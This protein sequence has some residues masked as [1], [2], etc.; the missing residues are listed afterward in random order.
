MINT[1]LLTTFFP[2]VVRRHSVFAF[3]FV[4]REVISKEFTQRINEILLCFNLFLVVSN[5]G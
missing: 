2:S 3:K 4:N 5:I 1:I